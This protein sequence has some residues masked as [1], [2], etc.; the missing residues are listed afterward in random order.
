[1]K[2]LIAI[3][4]CHRLPDLKTAQRETW[5]QDC[6]EYRLFVGRWEKVDNFYD[7]PGARR[8]G[9]H[10]EA[11]DSVP[12]APRAD[13]VW[14]DVGD[15]MRDLSEKVVHIVRWAVEQKYDYMF[16]CDCD[17][18]V[19]VPRLLASGFEKFDYIGYPIFRTENYSVPWRGR[20]L[21]YAQGGAGMWLS[22]RAMESFLASD[23]S[24][25]TFE[26]AEDIRMGWLLE[27]AGI[28]LQQDV[29][30]EPYQSLQNAPTPT[31]GMI[32]THKCCPEHMYEIHK[33]FQKPSLSS[34]TRPTGLRPGA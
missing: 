17:T 14:L 8:T 3:Q 15:W 26:D 32:S 22:R 2:M 28:P 9:R 21:V 31:N 23:Q 13:E 12:P 10:G 25:I 6:P 24:H 18:Y 11:A 5:L 7:R 1:M 29:R 33:R 19:H 20:D 34:L 4:A 27:E 30:Y 16:K